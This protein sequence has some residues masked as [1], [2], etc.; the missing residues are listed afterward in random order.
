LRF[1]LAHHPQLGER[2]VGAASG[3]SAN[4]ADRLIDHGAGQQCRPANWSS[5]KRPPTPSNSGLLVDPDAAT[6]SFAVAEIQII[7]HLA[8]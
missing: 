1:G 6:D 8:G 5:S 2:V 7:G 4:E 3:A